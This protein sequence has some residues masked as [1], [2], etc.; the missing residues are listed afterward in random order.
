MQSGLCDNL[1]QIA[2]VPAKK[3]VIDDWNV[4]GIGLRSS[5]LIEMSDITVNYVQ[6]CSHPLVK[7]KSHHSTLLLVLLH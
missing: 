6:L 1:Q 5:Q 2:A 7:S 3:C 4:D